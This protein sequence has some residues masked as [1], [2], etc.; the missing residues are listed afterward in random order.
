MNPSADFSA[1]IRNFFPFFS[2]ERRAALFPPTLVERPTGTRVLVLS[3]H[4]D[5][6]IIGCG[7]TLIKHIL[8]GDKVSVVYLTDGTNGTPDIADRN[9]GARVRKKESEAA[10]HLFGITDLHFLDEMEGNPEIQKRTCTRLEQILKEKQP[11]LI[12]LPWFGENHVDHLK[13][14]RIFVDLADYLRQEC[15]VCAY[16]VWTPLPPNTIV[17][18]G[19]VFDKKMQALECFTSQLK[20]NNYR[21]VVEGLNLYNTRYC[22]NGTSYAE[23]LLSA[24]AHIYREW[25]RSSLC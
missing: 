18:I 24:P 23:A 2:K 6:E 21:R 7:G 13:M 4:F 14:N 12:Y 8:G 15:L 3:P 5:D 20:H 25:V 9:E 17:D 11:D 22:L 1:Y 19:K 16:E 10:M